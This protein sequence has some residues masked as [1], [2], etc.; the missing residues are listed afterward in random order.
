MKNKIQGICFFPLVLIFFQ[1][2][3]GCSVLGPKTDPIIDEKARNLAADAGSLNQD[4]ESSKGTGWIEMETG[5]TREKFK[6]AWAAASP[7]RLR[8]TFLVSGHPVETIV[9]TGEQ[10]TFISHSGK[11]KPH[12]TA[13]NDP[14]LKEFIHV[15][16]KL[17]GMIAI[18]LGQ[19]PLLEFDH[20]WLEPEE[21]LS[22]SVILK[23]NWQTNF[24][25]IH[26]GKDGQIK[27]VL[28]LKQNKTLLYDITYLDFQLSGSNHIPVKLLIQ[29]SFGRKIH[30]SL[31]RFIP[32]PPIKESVFKLTDS[33]S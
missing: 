4:I 5:R 19:I 23:K 7:N 13:S 14:D 33:G 12:T 27:Q 32:N 25:K 28:F 1:L 9:A 22:S 3:F 8:I 10:V 17:S 31:T 24:Q 29:D 6:I 16:I 15:P 21:T 2:F 20:A 26:I 11:H 18:L 30:I